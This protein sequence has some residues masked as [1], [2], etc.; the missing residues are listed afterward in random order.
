VALC[1]SLCTA[2]GA[3]GDNEKP[4]AVEKLSPLA[5][6]IT[7]P[8]QMDRTLHAGKTKVGTTFSATT[9]QR[10]P[11]SQDA[12]L[13]RGA[14]VYGEVVTSDAGD[15]TGSH[16]S[17]LAFRFTKLKYRGETVPVE[18]TA[19]AAASRMAVDDTFFPTTGGPDRGNAS[20]ASWNT[21]QVG[22]EQVNRSGWVGD[23]IAQGLQK[24][25]S[26][27]YYGVYSLPVKLDGGMVPLAMGVFA[28]TAKGLYG[29]DY[30]TGMESEG[31]LITITDPKHAVLQSGDNLLL[32]VVHSR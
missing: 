19:V 1:V 14:K 28:T 12:F 16:S 9:T 8:V 4:R 6:G 15:G 2:A 31:G 25:G 3:S 27:D 21:M 7:L 17:V 24:V 10:V 32:M 20:A 22:G 26:A 11:V 29:Y 23:V 18:T 30:D 5:K 13:N